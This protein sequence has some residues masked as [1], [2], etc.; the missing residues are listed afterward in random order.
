MEIKFIIFILAILYLIYF[1]ISKIVSNV[2]KNNSIFFE[3][4]ISSGYM[5]NITLI[6]SIALISYFVHDIDHRNYSDGQVSAGVSDPDIMPWSGNWKCSVFG[7]GLDP[8][9]VTINFHDKSYDI[10]GKNPFGGSAHGSIASVSTNEMWSELGIPNLNFPK[11]I[12]K[13]VYYNANNGRRGNV[14]WISFEGEGSENPCESVDKPQAEVS[15]INQ[16]TDLNS[17][18]HKEFD[19]KKKETDVDYKNYSVSK[20]IEIYGK[21]EDYCRGAPESELDSPKCTTGRHSVV[22]ALHAKGFC[23]GEGADSEANS[24]WKKCKSGAWTGQ[25]GYS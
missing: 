21:L 17:E 25:D 13:W 4:K 15:S 9:D 24:S 10:I 8:T 5:S 12:G 18:N 3:N 16:F 19:K 1:I 2:F 7:E 23:W 11:P 14:E 22:E 20:L 6:A